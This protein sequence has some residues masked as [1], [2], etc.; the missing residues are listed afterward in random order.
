MPG[1]GAR[2]RAPRWRPPV[3][4]SAAKREELARLLRETRAPPAPVRVAGATT[5][6]GHVAHRVVLADHTLLLDAC[7]D[8]GRVKDSFRRNVLLNLLELLIKLRLHTQ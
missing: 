3:E 5:R 7:F 8:R 2:G 6:A 1:T 4:R